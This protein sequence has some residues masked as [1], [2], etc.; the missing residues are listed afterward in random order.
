VSLNEQERE[1]IRERFDD[2]LCAGCMK[3]LKAAYHRELFQNKLKRILGV[4]YK[5]S[6]H[7]GSDQ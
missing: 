3:E 1:F 5:K 2:C 6:Q 4:F 7:S